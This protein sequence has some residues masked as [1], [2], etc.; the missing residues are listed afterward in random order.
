MGRLA[1]D[2]TSLIAIF[3]ETDQHHKTIV[4][5]LLGS[6][7]RFILS[8]IALSE[9]LVHSFRMGVGDVGRRQIEALALEIIDVDQNIAV[10]AAQIRAAS[11]LKLGDALISATAIVHKCTLLTFDEKLAKATLGAEL[12]LP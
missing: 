6:K 4:N 3:K 12:L 2:S 7:D 11:N 10:L 5:R 9:S 8:T 1:L